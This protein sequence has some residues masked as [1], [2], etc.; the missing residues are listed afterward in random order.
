MAQLLSCCFT[1][2]NI[3]DDLYS[4]A[5]AHCVTLLWEKR[6][7][8]VQRTVDVS[9]P[10]ECYMA[11]HQRKKCIVCKSLRPQIQYK[12]PVLH[13]SGILY[14]KF[15]IYIRQEEHAYCIIL[16]MRYRIVEHCLHSF[17]HNLIT[18]NLQVTQSPILILRP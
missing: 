18:S 8:P 11:C 2:F 12:L 3:H 7:E 17:I 9:T 4:W 1:C 10:L 15:K 6:V 5:R 14:S 13:I 16:Y